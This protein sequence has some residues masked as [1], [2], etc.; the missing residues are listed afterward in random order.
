M[1][2]Q[3]FFACDD[4]E[5]KEIYGCT[6]SSAYNYDVSATI[7]DGSCEYE[8]CTDYTAANYDPNATIDDGSCEYEGCTDYTAANYDPDATIDDGSCIYEGEGVFWTDADYGVGFISVYVEGSYAGQITGY[9]S[10]TIPDC[11]ATGCVTITREPGTYNF[12]AEA[13]D[14]TNWN[15]YI[16]IYKNDCSTMR[17]YVSKGLEKA[18]QLKSDGAYNGRPTPLKPIK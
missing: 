2:R 3:F 10:S 6:D 16:T 9:Y 4:D 8:G 11:G 12:T 18:E 15:H 5:D 1:H 13:G 14:G 17:L 7:N